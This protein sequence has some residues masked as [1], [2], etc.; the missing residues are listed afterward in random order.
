MVEWGLSRGC[1]LLPDGIFMA[2]EYGK[3]D[4]IEYY[5]EKGI[6]LEQTLTIRAKGDLEFLKW[7]CSKGCILMEFFYDNAAKIGR[8]D[9]MDWL[10][11]NK[12]PITVDN[13]VYYA[14]VY[15]GHA[16]VLQWLID[17]N[18]T[19]NYHKISLL[20]VK[21]NKLNIL[22]WMYSIGQK[23]E[24][25]CIVKAVEKDNVNIIK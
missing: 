25:E 17:N 9:T 8:V 13:V 23:C 24:H 15:G 19:V 4:V 5:M 1:T 7:L 21:Y 6:E 12:C 2:I 10:Q 3:I 14:I 11:E 18:Y 20:A 22:K 16:N